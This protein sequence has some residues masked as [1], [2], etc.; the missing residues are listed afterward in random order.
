MYAVLIPIVLVAGTIWLA[1]EFP[2]FRKSLWITLAGFA[3]L[4]IAAAALVMY[5]PGHHG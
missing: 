3:L 4:L 5:R 1:I 2:R